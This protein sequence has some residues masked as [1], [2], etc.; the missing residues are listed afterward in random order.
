VSPR[1]EKA[2]VTVIV[3]MMALVTAIISWERRSSSLTEKH[4]EAATS[5]ST[6]REATTPPRIHRAFMAT[7][8]FRD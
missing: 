4:P 2:N 7:V 5:Q 1:I 3:A 8:A 6:A